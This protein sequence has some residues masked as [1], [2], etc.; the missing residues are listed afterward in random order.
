M[1]VD[2]GGILANQ[3]LKIYPSNVGGVISIGE[4]AGWIWGPQKAAEALYLSNAIEKIW[5]VIKSLLAFMVVSLIT[6]FVFRIGLMA[7]S[8]FVIICSRCTDLC[9]DHS[10]VP[11]VAFRAV[12]IIGV[13]AANLSRTQRRGT[14]FVSAYMYF[15]FLTYLFYGICFSI[16]H[17]FFFADNA[18]IINDPQYYY[19]Y[20]EVM[21]LSVL[22]FVRSR[23]SILYLPKLLTILNASYLFYLFSYTFPFSGLISGLLLSVTI[24]ILLLFLLLVEIPVLQNN[25]FWSSTPSTSNP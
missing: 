23:I 14:V 20:T 9:N 3:L 18:Y 16:W 2:L 1:L 22:L 4:I 25:P 15:L 8:I 12:P 24:V 5:L 13:N 17:N 6:A 11:S 7:S 10:T 19:P 21:E